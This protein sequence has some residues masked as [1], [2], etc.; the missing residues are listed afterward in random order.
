MQTSETMLDSYT[1]P[2][3]VKARMILTLFKTHQKQKELGFTL[4]SNPDNIIVAK[5][6]IE[7]TSDRIV[8]DSRLCGID[9]KFLGGYHTHFGQDSRPSAED[10]HYCGILKITCSGGNDNKIMC[11]TF[12]HNQLPAEEYNKMVYD[13][14]K[15]ETKAENPKYQQN[16]DC[17]RNIGPLF[18]EEKNLKE[19][20]KDLEKKKLR[21]LDL[22]NSGAPEREMLEAGIDIINDVRKIDILADILKRQI[23]DTS[24][25][26][27]NELEII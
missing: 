20:G 9:E 19:K 11:N 4:C 6:D 16:F 24:K 13:I 18:L 8:I 21:V 25:R 5:E 12:K 14:D 17:V 15:G 22:S 26:Y 3:R 2:E 27:Y 1:L 10:L 23:E 7:G